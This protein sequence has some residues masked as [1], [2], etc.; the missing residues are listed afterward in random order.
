MIP[1]WIHLSNKIK[2]CQDWQNFKQKWDK[3]IPAQGTKE[4]EEYQSDAEKAQAALEDII[5]S[6]GVFKK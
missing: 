4:F 2:N 3:N 6:A 5:V 1:I